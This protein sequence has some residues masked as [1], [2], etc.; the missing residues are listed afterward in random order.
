LNIELVDDPDIVAVTPEAG[1]MV[2]VFVALAPVIELIVIG[3]VS[4]LL[5]YVDKRLR[6]TGPEIPQV[7]K[8]DK[9]LVILE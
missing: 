8:S 3:K 6:V 7:A 5:L 2:I 9:A 1:L 4:V